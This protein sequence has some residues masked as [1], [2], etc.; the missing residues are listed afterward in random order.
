[1]WDAPAEWIN[2]ESHSLI[3]DLSRSATSLVPTTTT[4]QNKHR[5]LQR[6]QLHPHRPPSALHKL[7]TRASFARY[8]VRTMAFEIGLANNA[9]ISTSNVIT[10]R[11]SRAGSRFKEDV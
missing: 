7:A 11:K 1:M 6:Q 5:W 8:D 4:W 3:Y 2:R 10:M 9:R